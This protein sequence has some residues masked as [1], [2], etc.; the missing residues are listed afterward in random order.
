MALDPLATA[1]D[2]A[3]RL[4]RT[5]TDDE[6]DRAELLLADASAVV[7]AYCGQQFS[8]GESTRRLRAR[9]GVV[10]LPQGPVA[11]VTAV[12]DTDG[13]DVSFTYYAGGTVLVHGIAAGW[14]D[15]TYEHGYEEIPGDVVA[16]VCQVA[17][18]AFGTPADQTA[19]QSETIGDYSYQTGP[20]AAAGTVG[21]MNAEKAV[22]AQ[23]RRVGGSARTGL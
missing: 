20:T 1:D 2:L 21:M 5:L 16:V 19:L 13:A 3:G 4:G 18:R 12:T 10:R 8:L 15:V 22:L 11:D 9:D 7:R 6:T 14:V 17:G 23:Y